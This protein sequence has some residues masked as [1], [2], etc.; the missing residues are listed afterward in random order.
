[1]SFKYIDD[2]RDPQLAQSYLKKISEWTTKPWRIM[3]IC[4]G[5]THS[6]V[7]HGIDRVLPKMITL[8][9]GP[10]CPVC[11]TAISTIDSA[12]ALA[13]RPEVILC[14]FGD[15]LRVPGTDQDLMGIRAKCGDVRIVYSPMDALKTAQ[16]NPSKQVVFFAVGFETTTPANAMAAFIA[17][18]QGLKNFSLL[19]SQVLVPPA[20]ETLL[21]ADPNGKSDIDA[22]LAPGHVCTVVGTKAYQDLVKKYRVPIVVTGFEPGD[23][24]QGL[25]MCIR[26]LED[27]RHEVENQYTR[28]V[29]PEGNTAAQDLVAQVFEISPKVWRGMGRIEASGMRLNQTYRD[30]DAEWRFGLGEEKDYERLGCISGLILQGRKKP[31]ECPAF[32]RACRPENPLGATMVSSEGACSAYYRYR[33]KGAEQ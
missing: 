19:V 8:L 25:A 5:Q 2:Y 23:L 16:E 1:M 12:I 3:E 30:Y 17:R 11:V 32:G 21:S 10:G 15:M 28:V 14:T 27:G 31:D 6:I 9:H 22:F 33:P 7:R 18:Q 26:Q 20:I 24:L 4:G 29:R 13:S